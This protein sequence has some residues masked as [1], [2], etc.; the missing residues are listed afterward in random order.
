MEQS[1]TQKLMEITH[2]LLR[3]K[4][5][6]DAIRPLY[7]ERDQLTAELTSI[8]GAG[9]EAKAGENVVAVVDN[10]ADRNTVFRPASVSRFEVKIMTQEEY[11]YSKMS[12]SEKAAYTRA[13]KKKE[14]SSA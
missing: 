6:L 11:A 1:G 7:E 13:K 4:E 14:A 3:I 9:N 5:Q 2:R 12:K 8:V 10:F